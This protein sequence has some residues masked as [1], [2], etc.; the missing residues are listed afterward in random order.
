M[1]RWGKGV[2]Y[3]FAVGPAWGFG[4]GGFVV[5]HCWWLVGWCGAEWVQ[6]LESLEGRW[7]K[8]VSK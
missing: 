8:V 2:V 6:V 3:A 4:L 5:G 7:E 1:M